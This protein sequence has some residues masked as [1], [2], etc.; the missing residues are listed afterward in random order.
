MREAESGRELAKTEQPSEIA[1]QAALQRKQGKGKSPSQRGE[2]GW[3]N[4]S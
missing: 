4:N 2:E 3:R 1:T